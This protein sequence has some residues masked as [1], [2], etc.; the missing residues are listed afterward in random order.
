MAHHLTADIMAS[1]KP[2]GRVLAETARFLLVL[3]KEKEAAYRD[4]LVEMG[5]DAGLVQVEVEVPTHL[6]FA[7]EP[8]S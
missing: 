1:L 4:K 8:L 3:N 2:G 6:V 5:R 7:K